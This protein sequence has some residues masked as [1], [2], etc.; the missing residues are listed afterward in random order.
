MD[1][2]EVASI[3][4]SLSVTNISSTV[5]FQDAKCYLISMKAEDLKSF[6]RF[7]C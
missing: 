7:T 1:S 6:L 2:L 5:H 4:S 3:H